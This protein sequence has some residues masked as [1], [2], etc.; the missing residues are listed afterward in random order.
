M[1]RFYI[2][3]EIVHGGFVKLDLLGKCTTQPG[4]DL[5]YSVLERVSIMGI[6][7][8]AICTLP[9]SNLI[10][11]SALRFALSQPSFK[12]TINSNKLLKSALLKEEHDAI[13][14]LAKTL[15]S[16]IAPLT[17]GMSLSLLLL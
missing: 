7:L 8:G 10:A 3:P 11:S 17:V 13:Q 14:Y 1:Q 15:E 12:E 4:D 2:A 5:Y 16:E 6:P 9:Q